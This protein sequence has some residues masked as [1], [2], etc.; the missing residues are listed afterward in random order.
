MGEEDILSGLSSWRGDSGVRV[1]RVVVVM[2]K[3]W[4][5]TAE[6]E[7]VGD[8]S[9]SEEMGGE[10]CGFGRMSAHGANAEKEL[11]GQADL[12][13][14]GDKSWT[15][16]RVRSGSPT[17]GPPQRRASLLPGRGCLA[18]WLWRRTVPG[19]PVLRE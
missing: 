4:E 19:E 14:R 9:P 13:G 15:S 1:V 5:G 6:E 2:E 8:G 7:A 17:D 10:R 16:S 3:G 12:T 11:R 18:R